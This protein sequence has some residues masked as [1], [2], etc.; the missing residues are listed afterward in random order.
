VTE[1]IDGYKWCDSTLEFKWSVSKGRDTYGYDICSLYVDG[2]KVSSCY[3]IN[4]DYDLKAAIEIEDPSREV[5]RAHV[6]RQEKGASQPGT[7]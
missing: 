5:Q 1:V 2:K 3:G 7:F 6:S 4:N